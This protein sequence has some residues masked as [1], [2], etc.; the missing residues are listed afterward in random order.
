M[1]NEYELVNHLRI[2]HMNIF[3]VQ[4][5]YR[6]PHYHNEMELGLVLSGKVE[7]RKGGTV[8]PLR[9][10]DIFVIN[11]QETHELSSDANGS[12]I[13]SIQ[14]SSKLFSSHYPAIK[15]CRFL[16]PSLRECMPEDEYA[17][18]KNR[19][20]E[21]TQTY[22]KQEPYYEFPCV[23]LSNQILYTLLKQVSYKILTSE[24]QDMISSRMN[25][26]NRI[27]R[28]IED[29]FS[30]KLLLTEIAEQEKLT[31]TYLSHFFKDTLGM[32]FQDYLNQIRF[33]YAVQLIE[34]TDL[35]ILDVSLESGFSDVRYLNKLF[36][37][38]YG[39]SPKEY[40]KN[41][42]KKSESMN[43]SINSLQRILSSEESMN[44]FLTYFK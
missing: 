24:E 28:F 41:R 17:T 1:V 40:R 29:N 39:C 37:Q 42:I 14:F 34:T 30:R 4:L 36:R 10:S 26:M 35:K 6:T 2:K 25:R 38:R 31:L 44:Y 11:P 15:N 12:L 18:L 5:I 22:F 9:E 23:I 43:C 21:L 13:L 33:E 7:I 16:Q 32:S 19:M 27:T 20:L 3:L 8:Y